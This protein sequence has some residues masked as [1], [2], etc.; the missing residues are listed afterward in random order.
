MK[1][2]GIGKLGLF[3]LLALK[4][5]RKK[6]L[7]DMSM[8]DELHCSVQTSLIHHAAFSSAFTCLIAVWSDFETRDTRLLTLRADT[9]L[10][11]ANFSSGGKI[12]QR[13]SGPNF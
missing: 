12:H 4:K 1:N 5:G 7:E 11:L 2:D 13:L 10:V 8:I 6:K 3:V 9:L